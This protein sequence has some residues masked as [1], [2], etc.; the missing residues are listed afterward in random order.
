MILEFNFYSSLANPR[1]KLQGM[2][3][4]FRLRVQ[5]PPPVPVPDLIRDSPGYGFS[6]NR[7]NF[8]R[9]KNDQ[10][11]FCRIGQKKAGAKMVFQ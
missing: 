10:V 6:I 7:L 11:P 1:S 2:R 8:I 3:S 5:T 4:L 9:L